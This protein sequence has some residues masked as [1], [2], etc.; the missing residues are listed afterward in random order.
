MPFPATN[1]GLFDQPIP[2]LCISVSERD[3]WLDTKNAGLGKLD[4]SYM[5]YGAVTLSMFNSTFVS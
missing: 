2:S 1:A 4:N 5:K 3:M